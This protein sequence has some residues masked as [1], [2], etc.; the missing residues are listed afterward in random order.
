[1]I[2][3][4]NLGVR[5]IDI[6]GINQVNTQFLPKKYE[7]YIIYTTPPMAHTVP[8]IVHFRAMLS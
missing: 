2:D 7:C 6:K 5:S 3:I 1:M 4:D 8:L